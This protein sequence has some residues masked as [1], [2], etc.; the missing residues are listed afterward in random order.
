MG[1]TLALVEASSLF[2]AV[3]G[4]IVFWRPGHG[5]AHV[6]GQALALSLCYLVAFYFNDLY[7][8]RVVRSFQEFAPRLIQ[9]IGIAFI[10]VTPFYTF[11]PDTRISEQPFALSL[12]M[13]VTLVI[14]VRATSYSMMRSRPFIERVLI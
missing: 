13:I 4:A 6:M 1:L 12:L 11:L 2:T 5:T 14:A 8:L 3:F 7:D 10:L 9:S